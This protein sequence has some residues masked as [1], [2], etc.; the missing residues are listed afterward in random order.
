MGYCVYA[1][2]F[3][4]SVADLQCAG[5]GVKLQHTFSDTFTNKGS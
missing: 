4:N 2:C 5:C 3:Y 1:Y